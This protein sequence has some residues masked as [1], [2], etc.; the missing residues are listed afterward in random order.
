MTD[1][2]DVIATALHQLCVDRWNQFDGA[3]TR[4]GVEVHHKT[5]DVAVGALAAAGLSITETPDEL[6][7]GVRWESGGVSVCR[8]EADARRIADPRGLV[9]R[10]PRRVVTW[11]VAP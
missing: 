9:V 3:S 5:A 11:E 8:D 4:H 1:A 2:R 6:E 10:R 7:W